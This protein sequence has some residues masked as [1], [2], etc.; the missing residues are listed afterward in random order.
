MDT[1]KLAA[2]ARL[3]VPLYT[4]VN[5]TLLASGIN[6]LPFAEEEVAMAV[7]AVLGFV[8]TTYAWYKNANVTKEAQVAQLYLD[9]LKDKRK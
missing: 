9:E 2:F 6:P 8:S 5:A 4:F 1:Q 3:I 7:N